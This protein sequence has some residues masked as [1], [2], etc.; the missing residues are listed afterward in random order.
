[1]NGMDHVYVSP[2]IA[3]IRNGRVVVELAD[4]DQSLTAEALAKV[5]WDWARWHPAIEAAIADVLYQSR[6]FDDVAA[7]GDPGEM[8]NPDYVLRIALTEW[9]PGAPLMRYLVGWGAGRTRLQW[10]GALHCYQSGQVLMAFADA[11]ENPG[12]PS[13]F[14]LGFRALDT[15]RLL[16]DDLNWALIDLQEV[17]REGTDVQQDP[18]DRLHPH[19][20]YHPRPFPG[21]L[22]PHPQS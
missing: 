21:P 20:R 10:E 17:V 13:T 3:A 14:P 11:R 5:E 12:G 2:D 9:D 1:M 18:R 6:V 8:A 22:Y 19:P 4:P 7:R 16:R 15:D